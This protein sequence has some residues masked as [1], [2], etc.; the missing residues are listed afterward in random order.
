MKYYNNGRNGMQALGKAV[1]EYKKMVFTL[2][3]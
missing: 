2:K 1:G 3:L